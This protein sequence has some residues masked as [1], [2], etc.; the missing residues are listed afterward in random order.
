MVVTINYRLGAPGILAH[1]ALASRPGG[2]SENQELM[3]QQGQA[4]YSSDQRQDRPT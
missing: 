4:H 3:N 2:P 1:P